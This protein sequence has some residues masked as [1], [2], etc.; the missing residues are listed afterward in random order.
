LRALSE[1]VGVSAMAISKY[2]R[3]LDVAGSGV[4]LRLAQALGV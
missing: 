4:L 2:E 3:D 1:E